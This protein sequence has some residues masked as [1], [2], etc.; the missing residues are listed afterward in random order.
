MPNDERN[1]LETM[2][3]GALGSHPTESCKE[4]GLGGRRYLVGW[5]KRQHQ[6]QNDP[7]SGGY[8]RDLYHLNRSA[9]F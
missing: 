5:R 7:A 6:H 2:P 1:F 3:D 8:R 4:T 9:A